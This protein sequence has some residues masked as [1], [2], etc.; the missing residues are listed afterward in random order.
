M[1]HCEN[2][3]VVIETKYGSGRFC[4]AVCARSFSTKAK[5]KSINAKVSKTLTIDKQMVCGHCKVEFTYSKKQQKF[6][7]TSCAGFDIA[8]RPEIKA[9]KSAQQSQRIID[10]LLSG[11]LK[12]IRCTYEYK[13]VVIQ[14]D[15]KVEYAGLDWVINQYDV[16]SIERCAFMIPYEYEGTRNYVPDFLVKTTKGTFVLECK[17]EVSDKRLQRKWSRYYETIPFKKEAL[18]R[19]CAA[20][21]YTPLQFNKNMHSKFYYSCKPTLPQRDSN[22]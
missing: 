14:C 12:S 1:K 16:L 3:Q 8:H 9:A 18:D 22:S 21:E 7:S 10:G 11:R 2:C 19:Y 13:G 20:N 5:Q 15:S 4:S 17:G 6:C